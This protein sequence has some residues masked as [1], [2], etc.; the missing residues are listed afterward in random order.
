MNQLRSVLEELKRSSGEQVEPKD[1][2]NEEPSIEPNVES[3]RELK[4]KPGKEPLVPVDIL[5]KPAPVNIFK[6]P[7]PVDILEKSLPG[8][9]N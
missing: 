7:A 8:K 1:E 3:K 4:G 2:L 5:R 9:S 6:K